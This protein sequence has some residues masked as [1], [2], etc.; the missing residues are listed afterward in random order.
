MQL[1]ADE[2]VPTDLVWLPIH[3]PETNAVTLP[4]T[5]P[6]SDEPNFKQ[7]AVRL[8]PIT[9]DGAAEQAEPAGVAADD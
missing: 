1:R 4:E 6:R 2:A 5:D 3:H 8:D 9:E 7:C